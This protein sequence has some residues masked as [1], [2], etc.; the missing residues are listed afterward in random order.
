MSDREHDTFVEP[1]GGPGVGWRW[2]CVC[3]RR[4]ADPCRKD[5]AIARAE[6]H[7]ARHGGDS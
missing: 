1:A 5:H 6:A 3:G 2:V 7:R 4:G